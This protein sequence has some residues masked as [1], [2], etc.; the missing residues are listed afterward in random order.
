MNADLKDLMLEDWLR[1]RNN[2]SITWT[3]KDGKEIAIKDMDNNHLVNTIK[4]LVRQEEEI[5]HIG[6]MSPMDFWD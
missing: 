1:K 6:D 2:G 3:T 4:M 5:D